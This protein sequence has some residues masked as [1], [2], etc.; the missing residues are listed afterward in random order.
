MIVRNRKSST[1]LADYPYRRLQIILKLYPTPT[2]LLL[3]FDL[4][5]CAIL[6]NGSGVKMLPRT[7]R[8]LEVGCTSLTMDILHGFSL[9]NRGHAMLNRMLKYADRGFGT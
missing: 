2:D 9:A 1:M 6:F 4:D 3:S 7:A 8:A 5:P